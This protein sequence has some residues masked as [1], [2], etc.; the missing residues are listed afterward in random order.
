MVLEE[1]RATMLVA[2][3][4]AMPMGKVTRPHFLLLFLHHHHCL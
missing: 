3:I 4:M 1:T 2:M